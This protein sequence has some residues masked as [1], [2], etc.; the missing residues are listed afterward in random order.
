MDQY[1][2][3]PHHSLPFT[4]SSEWELVALVG[5]AVAAV[6]LGLL[7]RLSERRRG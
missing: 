7:I 6:A 5:F 2:N 4:G 3:S 1:A